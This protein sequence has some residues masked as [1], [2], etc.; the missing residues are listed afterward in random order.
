MWNFKSNKTEKILQKLQKFWRKNLYLFLHKR[1]I[2][3][4][5]LKRKRGLWKSKIRLKIKNFLIPKTKWSL[6]KY[7]KNLWLKMNKFMKMLKKTKIKKLEKSI[8]LKLPCPRT[9]PKKKQIKSS[10]KPND[11]INLDKK[12]EEKTKL[13]W[14]LSM[15]QTKIE[16]LNL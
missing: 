4:K 5:V 8:F 12:V 13:S 15:L 9:K 6:N 7:L 16:I 14:M 1:R 11:K 3:E 2:K 10:L